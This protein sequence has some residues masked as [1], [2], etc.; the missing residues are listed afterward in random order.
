MACCPDARELA[1]LAGPKIGCVDVLENVVEGLEPLA[2]LES[3][4]PQDRVLGLEG[5]QVVG[6][7]GDARVDLVVALPQST[8]LGRELG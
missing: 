5:Q 2:Q 6:G 8:H 1:D 7:D 3:L 4:S